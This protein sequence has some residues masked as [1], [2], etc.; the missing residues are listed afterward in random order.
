MT[1]T[2]TAPFEAA[3]PKGTQE[4]GG[5]RGAGPGYTLFRTS[6]GMCG[7][8]WSD[9]GVTRVKLPER[10]ERATERAL[11]GSAGARRSDDPP[12]EAR[13]AIRRIVH[14]L[15]GNPQDLTAIRLDL[16]GAPGFHRRVY[17]ELRRV[18]SGE[19][20][21]Y[22]ELAER[23]GSP[24]AAR[25]V[26]RAMRENPCAVVVP[27]H[28]VLAAN[29]KPGGFSAFGG[30]STKAKLLGIE[31]VPLAGPPGQASLPLGRSGASAT[32]A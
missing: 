14:H 3:V 15:A 8:A 1:A 30:F 18:P 19:T 6:I 2:R 32:R 26:G 23:V 7:I 31:G 11:A 17:E 27:C 12:A 10:S 20:V 9:R 25:A 29:G 4:E 21:S 5:S 16:D 22:G 13:E 24:G 28:R